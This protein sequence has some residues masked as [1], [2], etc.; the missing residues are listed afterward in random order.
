MLMVLSLACFT[1]SQDP[2][3]GLP[4]LRV[5]DTLEAEI[6]VGDPVRYRDARSV[7]G[8]DRAAIERASRRVPR[9]DSLI[10]RT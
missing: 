6:A 2:S 10:A 3:G 7:V 4:V 1:L 5:G 9:V 8:G